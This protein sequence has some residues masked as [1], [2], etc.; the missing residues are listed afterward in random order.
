[1]TQSPTPDSLMAEFIKKP[2]THAAWAPFFDETGKF[3]RSVQV[4]EGFFELDSDGKPSHGQVLKYAQVTGYDSGY[5]YLIPIG[6]Q[7]PPP[8][9][10][11]LE[12]ARYEAEQN[13]F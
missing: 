7:P 11:I 4:G 9:Q 6:E 8:P 5:C 3:V 13:G 1:M 2:A 10:E 12:A